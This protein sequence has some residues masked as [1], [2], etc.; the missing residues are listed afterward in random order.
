M[1]E[2]QIGYF[3]ALGALQD[4]TDDAAGVGITDDQFFPGII[5]TVK[6]QVRLYG[7]PFSSAAAVMYYNKALMAAQGRHA[8]SASHDY[9]WLWSNPGAEPVNIRVRVTP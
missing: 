4:L 8:P 5:S 3:M 1:T 7:F 9:C 2:D 6:W